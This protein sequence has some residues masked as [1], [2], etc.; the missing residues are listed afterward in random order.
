M[1][2]HDNIQVNQ[3]NQEGHSP[4]SLALKGS[5][6][7]SLHDNHLYDTKPI[8]AMLIMAGADVNVVYPEK[9]H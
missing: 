3:V 4:L 1:L 9:S 2:I 7:P 5:N 6:P 8:F